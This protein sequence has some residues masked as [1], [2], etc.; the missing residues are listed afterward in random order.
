[1]ISALTFL[2]AGRENTILDVK[3]FTDYRDKLVGSVS[4]A[5]VG[6]DAVIEK[7]GDE[8][9]AFASLV[10]THHVTDG[11]EVYFVES[12]SGANGLY[13][14]VCGTTLSWENDHMY[15]A[16]YIGEEFA[17]SGL[18]ETVITPDASY[19]LVATKG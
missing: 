11:I 5:I 17:S 12:I 13:D 14:T 6:K 16:F 8:W 4:K 18:D 2:R 9:P 7:A 3:R 1:M 19:S 10:D 15:W